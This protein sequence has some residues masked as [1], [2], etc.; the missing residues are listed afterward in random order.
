MWGLIDDSQSTRVSSVAWMV[1][2][3]AVAVAVPLSL[4]E[5]HMHMIH[6]IEPR[7]QKYYIRILWMVPMYAIESW[8]ALRFQAQ[9]S[10]QADNSIAMMP[11]DA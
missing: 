11:A 10:E 2:G 6:Y 8:L 4:H 1:S 7:L 9:A 5:I 3:I